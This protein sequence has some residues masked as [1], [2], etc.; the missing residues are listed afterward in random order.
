MLY[1]IVDRLAWLILRLFWRVEVHFEEPMPEGGAILSANH[2]SF[3]DP[4]LVSTS[5]PDEVH[6]LAGDYLFKVP[7]FGAFIR[8]VNAHPVV[9]GRGDIGAFRLCCKLLKE[10]KKLVIFPEGT[11]SKTGEFQ[12]LKRGVAKM[13]AM[14]GAKVI[15]IYID[16]AYSIWGR[17]R[18]LPKFW[19]KI[20]I[21]YGK[22]LSCTDTG[23]EEKLTHDLREAIVRLRPR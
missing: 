18:R 15:P 20:R 3:L 1:E 17:H 5:C 12:P 11:R 14:T 7:L 13:A 9:R 22:A 19:G 8:A 2:T 23:G 4:P 10:G 16:G 21:Y 6:F